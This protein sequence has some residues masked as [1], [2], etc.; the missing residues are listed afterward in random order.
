[1]NQFKPI[2]LCNTLFKTITKILVLR[3][4]PFLNDLVHPL[5]ASFV[6]GRKASD[7][8]IMVQEI[9]HSM[10]TSRSKVGNLAIKIDL[11]KA[12][13]HLEWSLFAIHSSSSISLPLGSSSLCLALPPLLSL[14]WTIEIILKNSPPQ[15]VL[16]K[17]KGGPL[18]TYIFILCMEYLAWLIQV[19]V[20]GGHW[21]GIKASRN[22]PSFTHLF[23]VDD[24]I[25]F[26]KANKK[27]C[28]AIT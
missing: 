16:D 11:E 28:Q 23:F 14:F 25:L 18:S 19:E 7:N 8:V 26:A 2:G 4:K 17:G 9:V 6:P 3:L 15:E 27:S 22:G 12:Y 10:I 20:D 1:M 21:T 24:L 5:Q 13:D